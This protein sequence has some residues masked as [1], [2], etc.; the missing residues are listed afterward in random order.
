MM[1]KRIPVSGDNS[2]TNEITSL[3]GSCS[4]AELV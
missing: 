4:A 3:L 1:A 2:E